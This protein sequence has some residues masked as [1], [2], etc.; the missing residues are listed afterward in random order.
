MLTSNIGK[1]KILEKEDISRQCIAVECAQRN[2]V[3]CYVLIRN[4]EEYLS[5]ISFLLR[6]FAVNSILV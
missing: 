3:K 4:T 5:F 1:H 6:I 2:H